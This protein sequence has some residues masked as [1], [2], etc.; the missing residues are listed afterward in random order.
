MQRT[1][2]RRAPRSRCQSVAG[3]DRSGK[4]LIAP[5][6]PSSTSPSSVTQVC[7]RPCDHAIRRSRSSSGYTRE[8]S[9]RARARAGSRESSG[10]RRTRALATWRPGIAGGRVSHPSVC[11]M[12]CSPS[13][14]SS[15]RA[16]GSRFSPRPGAIWPE[17]AGDP[18]AVWGSMSFGASPSQTPAPRPHRSPGPRGA[19]RRHTGPGVFVGTNPPRQTEGRST[20]HP[21]PYPGTA[22]LCGAQPVLGARKPPH[23]VRPER[24]AR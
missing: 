20:G 23:G 17:A 15:R 4:R 24:T 7:E 13:R 11:P 3:S 2:Q 22:V 12:R 18:R 14:S 16:P 21:R 19:H 5:R 1:G 9:A 8:A 10:A 6:S